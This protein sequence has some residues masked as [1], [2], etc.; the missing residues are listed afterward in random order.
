MQALRMEI[1]ENETKKWKWKSLRR[2][3][4]Q[5]PFNGQQKY[6]NHKS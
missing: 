2:M 6:M 3:F 1:Y 4:I 5:K